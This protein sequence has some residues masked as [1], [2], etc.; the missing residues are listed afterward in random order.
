[1]IKVFLKQVSYWNNHTCTQ[2]YTTKVQTRSKT[3][4][5]QVDYT[6][7]SNFMQLFFTFFKYN[8]SKLDFHQK[9]HMLGF[10]IAG[11]IILYRL[12]IHVRVEVHVSPTI[13]L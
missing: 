7:P 9:S 6:I 1:M 5:T 3:F 4:H 8:N 13:P 2:V 11:N 12:H 10:H